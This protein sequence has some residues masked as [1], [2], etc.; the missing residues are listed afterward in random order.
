MSVREHA[1]DDLLWSESADLA[2]LMDEL[3]D[4]AFDH[5]SLCD[6][7][8]VRDVVSHPGAGP[9]HADAEDGRIK[10]PE[11]FQRSSGLEALGNAMTDGDR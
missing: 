1:H 7:W 9:R 10:C 2:A 8:R 11:R 5:A 3:D 6:G 4:A